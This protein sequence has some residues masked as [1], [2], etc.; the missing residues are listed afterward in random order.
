MT[1]TSSFMR[2]I[3]KGEAAFR[4]RRALSLKNKTLDE[5]GKAVN[6]LYEIAFFSDSPDAVA[7][8]FC[9][10]LEQAQRYL[11]GELKL[12]RSGIYNAMLTNRKPEFFAVFYVNKHDEL[13]CLRDPIILTRTQAAELRPRS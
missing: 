12:R 11:E 1:V 13:I 9:S 2:E 4:Y 6:E 7:R 5:E 10:E 8:V 3:L